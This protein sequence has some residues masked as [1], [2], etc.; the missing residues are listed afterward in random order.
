MTFRPH[1]DTYYRMPAVFGPTPGPRQW[2]QDE[3]F[4]PNKQTTTSAAISFLTRAGQLEPLLPPGFSL[5]GE[6][7]V[8]LDV[9]WMKN[10]PWLAGRGYAMSDFKFPVVFEGAQGP[11]HGQFVLV[12]WENLADPILSG[13]D[14]LGHAKLYCEIAE[15][16]FGAGAVSTHLGWLGHTFADL[17]IRELKPAPPAAPH[18]M[19]QGQLHFKYVPR[20]GSP[21]QA[22]AAYAVLSPRPKS[23]TDVILVDH[24]T[25]EGRFDYRP[26]RWS[27]FPFC[28]HVVSCIAGLEILEQRG[29]RLT[30]FAGSPATPGHDSVALA[31]APGLVS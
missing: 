8:T 7:V 10:I 5:W 18:P 21:G 24:Q 30:R 11:V 9:T 20:T 19:D 27:E 23:A 2:P 3:P 28:H 25:G 31:S 22:D 14:E 13:R 12:R 26:T 16:E 29:A 4:D 6:P 1:P 17:D 15:P